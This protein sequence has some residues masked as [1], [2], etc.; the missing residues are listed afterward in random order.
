[1]QLMSISHL[2]PLVQHHISN[3]HTVLQAMAE[4]EAELAAAAGGG[5]GGGA[6]GGGQV[7]RL[8]S[9]HDMA[10]RSASPPVLHSVGSPG[11]QAPCGA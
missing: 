5:S 4:A 11:G 7:G 10:N 9:A 8:D 1:M 6:G 3:I 2:K